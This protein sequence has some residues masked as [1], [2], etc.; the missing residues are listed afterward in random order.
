M[1][2]QRI[3][4]DGSPERIEMYAFSNERGQ[5][6]RL[7]IQFRIELA[8]D[9]E[10]WLFFTANLSP[11]CACPIIISRSLMATSSPGRFS[12]ALNYVSLLVSGRTIS[13][14]IINDTH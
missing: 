11:I 7:A 5:G 1:N 13:C 3:S 9:M 8:S 6:L 10:K 2:A 4:M 12:L 14:Y